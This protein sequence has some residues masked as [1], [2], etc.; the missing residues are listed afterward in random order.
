M[1]EQ[2]SPGIK[3]KNKNRIELRADL[4]SEN[5]TI[6]DY[7]INTAIIKGQQTPRKLIVD[8]LLVQS[9]GLFKLNGFRR[10]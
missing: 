5:L 4:L 6:E 10:Y 2:E 1:E 7:T 3:L 8:S 9:T